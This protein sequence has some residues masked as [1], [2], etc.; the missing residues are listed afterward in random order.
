[1]FAHIKIH[2]IG[3]RK[4]SNRGAVWGWFTETGKPEEPLLYYGRDACPDPKCHMFYGRIG[5]ELH[6]V[7]FGLTNE[8]LAMIDTM[9]KNYKTS[10]PEKVI[11]RW[12]NRFNEDL[13]M[14]LMMLKI[15]G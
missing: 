3:T 11:P 7:E 1:M 9:K 12:G 10:E 8:F 14:Y 5:R 4:D 6:I 15:K 2:W 13:S